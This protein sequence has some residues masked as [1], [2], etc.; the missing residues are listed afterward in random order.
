MLID[1]N[2]IVLVIGDVMLDRYI[3]G[4]TDRIS[5]EAS[6]LIFRKSKTISHQLG[7]AA[8]VASQ[9]CQSGYNVFLAGQI[10]KDDIGTIILNEL[11]N[12]GVNTTLISQDSIIT[13]LKERYIA[14]SNKQV[15]RVDNE[16]YSPFSDDIMNMIATFIRN[17]SSIIDCIVL[18]DYEKGA[19]SYTFC[20]EVIELSNRCGVSTVVDIKS[21]NYNKYNGAT[22]VKGNLK[23]FCSFMNK[24]NNNIS[25]MSDILPC[26]PELKQKLN[27]Q[28][29]VVTCGSQGM[30][31]IDI[32]NKVYTQPAITTQIYDVTGAGDIV[33]AFICI[34]L[35]MKLSFEE[36][37][38]FSNIAA[39]I[40]V[41]RLGNAYINPVEVFSEEKTVS[42]ENFN[43]LRGNRNVI[44]T[45]GCFDVLH[46]GHIDLLNQAKL[47]G[48]TL[49]VGLN[50]DESVKSLKGED[51]PIN[52]FQ[53]RAKVLSALNMV[54]YII[55]FNEL[56]PIDII[57]AIKPDILVKGGD[58]I[59]DEIVGSDFV[60]SYGGKVVTI[61]ITYKTSTTQILGNGR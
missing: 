60:L 25:S 35:C 52:P 3:F 30:A 57:K 2:K 13:T 54:D 46:I 19:L 51:R 55:K 48:G 11:N 8:N 24:E 40:S 7:G 36:M 49:V 43:K 23:E 4:T 26:I 6:C 45:N 56:T 14:D 1:A 34:S 50:S 32:N 27:S 61:P 17:N 53:Y 39:S 5:P 29:V 15:L 59:V 10:A 44:F 33:T 21:P 42:V 28:Y 22:I 20:R 37:L 38:R 12:L 16:H 58:Y 18:S 31:A 9:L 47:L 41:T